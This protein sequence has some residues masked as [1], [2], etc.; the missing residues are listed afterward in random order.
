MM[1]K[2]FQYWTLLTLFSVVNLTS[3][4]NMFEE[5]SSKDW[6]REQK[7]VFSV[8]AISLIMSVFAATFH[9]GWQDRFAGKPVEWVWVSPRFD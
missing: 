4:T 7:W 5:E 9:I 6:T 3:L 2:H 8:A 1:E